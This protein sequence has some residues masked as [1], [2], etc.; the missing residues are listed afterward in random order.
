[1]AWGVSV[2]FLVRINRKVNVLT[3]SAV[4]CLVTTLFFFALLPFNGGLT[5]LTNLDRET[6]AIL[7]ASIIFI[8]VIGDSLFFVAARRISMVRAMPLS[9]T[10]PL[11]TVVLAAIF[12][13]ETITVLVSVGTAL[14]LAGAY[15]LSA[16]PKLAAARVKDKADTL[17][18]LMVLASALFFALGTI[19]LTPVSQSINAVVANCVRQPVAALFLLAA[20][21]KQKA[22]TQLRSLSAKEW[23]ML[24]GSSLA[25]VGVGALLFIV[26]LQHAGASVTSVLTAT[27][28]VFSTPFSILLLGEKVRSWDVIGTVLI[29]AGVWL[30]VLA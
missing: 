9:M 18:I 28:P 8:I 13:H 12:L 14:I 15:L 27:T 2:V 3:T 10:L 19:I 5:A 21:P 11:F 6:I 4:R 24:I 25:G 29:M 26:A 20:M 7:V 22:V 17:G 23:V 1:M 16:E 30:V